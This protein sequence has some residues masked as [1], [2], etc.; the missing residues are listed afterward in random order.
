MDE[1]EGK[2]YVVTVGGVGPD[3]VPFTGS[4]VCRCSAERGSLVFRVC[5]KE[6]WVCGRC[7][8]ACE[9]CR[10]V[11]SEVTECDVCHLVACSMCLIE[12]QECYK[13]VCGDD[14]F[15]IDSEGTP[16]I[17]CCN[18][19][20]LCGACGSVVSSA[21]IDH[22]DLCDLSVCKACL[23]GC[24]GC[25]NDI[26]PTHQTTINIGGTP[27]VAC[28]SCSSNTFVCASCGGPELDECAD[29]CR[30]CDMEIC[31]ECRTAPSCTACT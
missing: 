21:S 26:C 25:L 20:I 31:R 13:V 15:E 11:V 5:D 24:E 28:I 22:C 6:G 17:V 29:S 30:S 18:C 4:M 9:Q 16:G 19:G 27:R 12:C 3:S 14:R 10:S 7:A 8:A 1:I 23:V 2:I